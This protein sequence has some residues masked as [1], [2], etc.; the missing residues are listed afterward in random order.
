MLFS[1]PS[2]VGRFPCLS[3]AV[4]VLF[5]L[6]LGRPGL[7]ELRYRLGAGSSIG[8]SDN[9]RA[10]SSSGSSQ[11]DGFL[12]VQGRFQLSHIGPLML[13]QI[14]YGITA[15]TWSR[16]TR[17]P[18]YTQ[19]LRLASELQAGPATRIALTGGAAWARMS[20]IDTAAPADPQAV[21]LRPAGDQQFLTF[22]AGEAF[23]W[24]P[25]SSW[26][27]EQ[28]LQ[29]RLYR[30]VGSAQMV[31]SNKSLT[32]DAQVT[33][34]RQ[35]D[36]YGLRGRAGAITSGN[37]TQTGQLVTVSRDSQFAEG[38]LSWR[39]DWTPDLSHELAAGVFVLRAD[40]TR[41]LP[42]LSAGL[43]WRRDGSEIGLLAGR[44]AESNIYIGTAYERSF[45]TLRMALPVDRLERIRLFADANLEHDSTS[46]APVGAQGTANI[47]SARAGLRWQ[48]GEMFGCALEYTF[49]DQRASATESGPSFFSTYRRHMAVL[50][51]DM[52][53]PPGL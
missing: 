20:N 25:N 40:E 17:G 36:S 29:G 46:A 35:Q 47:L 24:Q 33:H 12:T 41:L 39:H 21:G 44:T 34:L 51:I 8:A 27:L 4:L 48:L 37:G 22:D 2:M 16:N 53:Y 15:T 43:G 52:N 45:V 50:T 38:A 42:A 49:R 30:P 18:T 32:V 14:A 23:S 3:C 7:A 9:P 1:R 28:G 13:G 19:T 5:V 10:Q 26:R 11:A 31:A 6:G